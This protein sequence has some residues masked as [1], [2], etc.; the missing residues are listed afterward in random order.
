MK[1]CFISHANQVLKLN[2]KWTSKAH[3]IESWA[4]TLDADHFSGTSGDAQTWKV[5]NK[6]DAILVNQ[7]TTMFTL[8]RQIKQNCPHPFLIAV[9]EGSVSDIATFAPKTMVEMIRAATSVDLYA[10]LLDWAAPCYSL[11]TD[12]PVRWIGLPFYTDFFSPYRIAHHKRPSKA[13][14]IALQHGPGNHRNGLASFMVAAR[15]SGCKILVPGKT[16]S[17]HELIAHLAI[18]RVDHFPYLPWSEYLKK[19]AY[20]YMAIHLDTLYTYGRFPLDMAALG[21]P[22]IGSNRNQTNKILFPE[23]TIDPIK[24]I[25]RAHQLATRLLDDEAFYTN[26]VE[27]GRK[28]LSIF[29]PDIARSRLLAIIHDILN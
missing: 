23:L 22:T 15:V 27:S 20:A 21:V 14:L 6:Y 8:T 7:N 17:S 18:P 1:F 24:D 5:L 2:P 26:Q 9:A 28:A 10:I 16:E 19:Y 13:R 11:I 4:L 3:C 25:S 29:S 12:K